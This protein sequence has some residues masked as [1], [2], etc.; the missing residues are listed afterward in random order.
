[1]FDRKR[2]LSLRRHVVPA[3]IV[4]SAY[5]LP[6]GAPAA[7]NRDAYTAAR[8]I[9]EASGVTGGLVVHLG[10]GDGRLTTALGAE[11]A[12]LVHGLDANAANTVKA[13]EHIKSRGLYG[14][15]SVRQWSEER[16]PYADNLVNLLVVSDEGRVPREELMRVLAPGGVALISEVRDQKSEISRGAERL[17]VPTS[18]AGEVNIDG[19]KWRR[20]VK[21]W[22][23]EI[24]EWTHFLHDASNNAVAH[25]T[26]VGPP[27]HTQW[28]GEPK[29][30]RQHEHLA[31][32]T[33]VVSA[34][35]RLFYIADEAPAASI[36]FSPKW[37]LVARDAFNGV[38]LWKREISSWHP[39]LWKFRQ[40]PPQLSRRLVAIDDRV[41]VTLG[42]RAP[43]TCLDA[44]TGKTVQTYEG[45]EGAE[46]ILYHD[47]AL[48]LVLGDPLDEA[49]AQEA[50]QR[51]LTEILEPAQGWAAIE[52]Q[53]AWDMSQ[54]GDVLGRGHMKEVKFE[55]G[56]MRF[57]TEVDPQFVLNLKGRK[58]D[59]SYSLLAVRMYSSKAD[60]GQVYYWS[61]DGE[62]QGFGFPSVRKGWHTYYL[63]INHARRHGPGGGS[64]QR[65]KWGGKSGQI[66][67]FR[68]DPVNRA[69]TEVKIDW[70]KLLKA[71]GEIESRVADVLAE[72]K[73]VVAVDAQSGKHLWRRTAV[74]LM[75]TTLAAGSDRVIFQHAEAV[76]CLD[77]KTGEQHWQYARP[78]TLNRPGWS[79][80][81]LVMHDGVVLCADRV[82][83][84]APGRATRK[85]S[86]RERLNRRWPPGTLVA[87][88]A[89]TGEKLWGAECA[90]GYNAPV[91]VFVADGLVWL[92]KDK[93]RHDAD[94]NE[95]R[96]LR[97]GEVKRRIETAKAFD[98]PFHHRCYRD[99]ATDKYVLVGKVGVEFI[100][101]SSGACRQH[102]WLRGTCQHGI[103]PCN[104]L[105]YVPPH[106]CACYIQSK[107]NGFLAMASQRSEV[108][109]QRSAG[110]L[111]RGPA[112]G[113]TIDHRPPSAY[114][115]P[116]YRHDAARSG[117]TKTSV[118]A[119]LKQVWQAKLGGKLTS[120][121]IAD[122]TVFVA[123]VDA[124]TVYAIDSTSGAKRWSYITGG[125]VDSPPTI[126][127]GLVLF[128]SAD[129]W[130]YCL[131][132]SDGK[133]AWRFRAA[134]EER[135]IAAFGQ[136][137]S[138]WPVHGSVLVQGDVL[139]CTAGRSSYLDGGVYLYRLN[140]ITGQLLTESCIY[141]LDPETGE[142]KAK[143]VH[144]MEMAGGLPDV[145]SSDGQF[146]FMRHM[147][148]DR[149]TLRP[150]DEFQKLYEPDPTW[151]KK[152]SAGHRLYQNPE[153]GPHVFCPTGF[154]DDSWWHRCYWV[155]GTWFTGCCPYYSAAVHTPAGRILVFDDA[156]VYGFGRKPKF[157]GWWTPLEYSLFAT[158]KETKLVEKGWRKRRFP[159]NWQGVIRLGMYGSK[160]PFHWRKEVPLHVRAMVLADKTLFVAG[161]PD[162]LDETKVD[163]SELMRSDALTRET[164]DGALAAWEGK[165]GAV[166]CAV[167]AADGKKLVER[168][169]DALPVFDGM[170]A[171]GGQLYLSMADGKLVCMAGSE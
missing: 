62:W 97:T 30:T 143:D 15:V 14:R 94:Y 158:S 50:T 147:R 42:Y 138:A 70:I 10:C 12:F 120:P 53:D 125:R 87:L 32:I 164:L 64:D 96:D 2:C 72:K 127:R 83:E 67:K 86:F 126:Y 171:A 59:G 36:L 116:T 9:L 58:I 60:V 162:V 145:L 1:M 39:H 48:F 13:R 144:G 111:Q 78:A 114:P 41:Y 156:S 38:V 131:R 82:P 146:V 90:E 23:R 150:L 71:D 102:H 166:L 170:A 89:K 105:L 18:T 20:L 99:K 122:G 40:G 22:P 11:D 92:G 148:L 109:S 149:E 68:F 130:V 135:W 154:L 56:A 155:Y 80:P 74:D 79:A 75:P 112:Y 153:R 45:T 124:H 159:E 100:D 43:V 57:V 104:G 7:D 65:I 139:Y 167:S 44:A 133:L 129:G 110:R 113:T 107:L 134:P 103:L 132:A 5:L 52:R 19:R 152:H 49:A 34:Q 51:K 151:A 33:T 115:W 121:V 123:S 24:D 165:R 119:D 61:P 128:G 81:T 27:R 140:P 77:R 117:H 160:V 55:D 29:Q 46:E 47:G 3:V 98:A 95:G 66:S 8:Q 88:S 101:I 26:V 69:D 91:D 137:E 35:G 157:L 4:F 17:R 54:P 73:T 85:L 168:K 169:L 25:D 28:L 76:V 136:V 6:H 108:R 63:D 141:S 161:P 31:S 21:R 37:A 84:W 16:L 118:P 93:A 163:V 142:Q 106:A